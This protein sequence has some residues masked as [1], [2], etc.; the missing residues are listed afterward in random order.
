MLDP[1]FFQIESIKIMKEY[2]LV[3]CTPIL[4]IL[5]GCANLL[6]YGPPLYSVPHFGNILYR[7]RYRAYKITMLSVGSL[8]VIMRPWL[9]SQDLLSDQP[10]FYK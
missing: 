5:V 8:C 3:A 7:D 2:C 1:V 9:V 10:G 6:H 4:T